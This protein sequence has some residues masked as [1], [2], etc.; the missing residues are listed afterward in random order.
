VRIVLDK[1]AEGASGDEGEVILYGKNI[2]RGYHKRDK[3]TTAAVTEDGGLRTGDLGRIDADGYLFIT[4]RAK[5]LFKLE[6][7]KYV[8]P[9]QLE[10]QLELSPYIGQA[11]VYGDNKPHNVA[12][13]IPDFVALEAWTK[14]EAISGTRESL[15]EHPRVL[16]LLEAEVEKCNQRFKGYE[17]I[18]DFLIDTEELTPANGMLTLTMKPK[19]RSIMSRYGHDI[20]ALYPK[21]ESMRPAPRASYIRELRPE[22]GERKVA[23]GA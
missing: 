5:E 7:G 10:Q 19:R 4:G 23:R 3:E 13:I 8:A 6:N 16:A 2:M 11:I 20:E 14:S 21:S 9:V 12:L 15:L 17:R 1:T 22:G 18:V